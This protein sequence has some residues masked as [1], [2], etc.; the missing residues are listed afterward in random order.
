MLTVSK[1]A[2]KFGISR[3]T[4]LY[5]E[6][7]KLITPSIKGHNGYRYYDEKDCNKLKTIVAY[8]NYGLSIVEIRTL[9]A[10]PSQAKQFDLFHQHFLTLET[11]IKKIKAQQKAIIAVLQAPE[12]IQA[13]SITKIEWVSILKSAGYTEKDMMDWHQT[14]EK[15]DPDAH[16]AFLTALG[17]NEEEIIKIR[18][19]RG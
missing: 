12:M 19:Y 3:T 14:Y 8:R 15:T 9:L 2:K 7:E 16:F 17:I 18:N 6:K 11:E 1:L 13:K 4:I 10:Q 5:Y